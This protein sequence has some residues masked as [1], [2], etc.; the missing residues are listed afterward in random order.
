MP[1]TSIPLLSESISGL[2]SKVGDVN[3]VSQSNTNQQ[4]VKKFRERLIDEKEQRRCAKLRKRE[5]NIPAQNV[6]SQ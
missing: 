2:I 5:R 1:P 3:D 6:I 4:P